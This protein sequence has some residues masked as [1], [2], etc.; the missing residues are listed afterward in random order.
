MPQP[1][2]KQR[3]LLVD[4]EPINIQLLVNLFAHEYTLMVATDGPTAIEVAKS[5]HQPHLILLDINMPHMDG[6]EVCNLLKTDAKT[7]DIPIIFVTAR[8]DSEDEELGINLGAVDYI[9]K[10]FKPAIV[11]A[12]VKSILKRRQAEQ[13][14]KESEAKLKLENERFIAVLDAMDAV[15]Y[16]SDLESAEILF[17]NKYVR[18]KFGDILGKKCY[19][20]LQISEDICPF[21]TN[22]IL[23]EKAKFGD[24]EPYTW[25][26]KN[27]ANQHYYHAIDRLIKWTDGRLVRFEI[28]TDITDRKLAEQALQQSENELKLLNA[29]KDKFFNIIAHDLR[30]PF[31]AILSFSELLKDSTDNYDRDAICDFAQTIYDASQNAYKLVTN[32]LIWSRTQSGKISFEPEDLILEHVLIEIMSLFESVAKAKN[33]IMQRNP[34]D[35]ITIHA[36]REMV[37]TILRNLINNAIKFTPKHG[38]ITISARVQTEQTEQVEISI[39]DTGVGMKPE[40]VAKLFHIDANIK[41][42]GTE[43][44]RGTGLGLLLCKEFVDRHDG[45]IEVHSQ[46]EQG[47]EFKFTLPLSKNSVPI[48]NQ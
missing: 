38:K 12:R 39:V 7:F 3:I 21:C 6:Y 5:E 34:I 28:A 46:L 15:A 40:T 27:T 1:I 45:N 42:L 18:Q 23:L 41:S 37:F 20:V 44:E 47:S 9:T 32:L 33:I 2:D 29:T 13:A 35:N 31:N 36:D 48:N 43:N 10:P 19:Q 14:L 17:A 16:V 11:L 25:E 30:S 22:P 8:D 24:F 26:F 4:D